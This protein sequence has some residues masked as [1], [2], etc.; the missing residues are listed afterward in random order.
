M[1]KFLV[2]LLALATV[3]A[4][5][6]AARADSINF[7]TVGA[8]GAGQAGIGINLTLSSGTAT[9]ASGYVTFNPGT[10]GAATET[11][12][13]LVTGNTVWHNNPQ[14]TSLA[15]T[16]TPGSYD[17]A[18]SLNAPYVDNY[19]L[20]LTLSNGDDLQIWIDANYP[21]F[22]YFADETPGVDEGPPTIATYD[23][24]VTH[25]I[26]YT[27][28][29]GSLVLFGTGLVGLAGLLRRKYMVSR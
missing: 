17:Q 19:G 28:E 27:P 23:E 22:V 1:K 16:E 6:P 9:A 4:V 15:G 14:G 18:F 13:G 2:A 24:T 21:T 25:L 29:P 8:T 12:T 3:V 10:V 20:A 26:T 5:S 7:A 11:I